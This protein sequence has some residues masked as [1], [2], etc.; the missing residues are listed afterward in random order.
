VDL[1]EVKQNLLTEELIQE[2]EEEEYKPCNIIDGYNIVVQAFMNDSE[3][4]L[5]LRENDPQVIIIYEPILDFMRAIELYNAERDE[6]IEVHVLKFTG[7]FEG[8]DFIQ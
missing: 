8:S 4:D 6:P 7:D 1:K 3:L 2:I 5:A